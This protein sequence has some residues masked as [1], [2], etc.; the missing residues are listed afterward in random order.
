MVITAQVKRNNSHHQ[1]P[2]PPPPP[3][4]GLIRHTELKARKRR[5]K[6]YFIASTPRK[7]LGNDVKVKIVE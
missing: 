3:P 2:P 1:G 6:T 5:G 7:M 4:G